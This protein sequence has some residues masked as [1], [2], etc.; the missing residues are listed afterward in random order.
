V[1]G[2]RV[3]EPVAEVGLRAL[4]VDA[5]RD[6]RESLASLV[7]QAGFEPT[8]TGSVEQARALCAQ[9]S[10]D[11]VLVELEIPAGGGLAL[12]RDPDRPAE[13]VVMTSS[14]SVE[15][16]VAA[17]RAG[18]IDY[19]TKP[20]DRARLGTVLG[21]IARTRALRAEVS[22]LRGEL[23]ELGRYGYLVGNSPPMQ[24]V[25]RLISKVA[26]TS[27]TVLIVGESGTGKELVAQ[28]I[29]RESRRSAGRFVAVNC[30]ALSASLAE[31][32]LFGHE[33]G[34]FTGAEA[35]RAGYFEEASG[36]TLFLDEITE[37]P[38]EL[39]VK[40]LRVLEAGSVRRVGGSESIPVDVRLMAASN[41]DPQ[42][43]VER[44]QLRR[45]VLYRLS[46]FPI[47]VPPLRERDGDVELLAH[48]FLE[49]VNQRDGSAKHF[50]KAA[51]ECLRAY[52]WP[53]NVREL[54]NAVERAAIVADR[55]IEPGDLPRELREHPDVP[56]VS[57]EE[58][59]G[60]S[61]A[62][63]VGTTL[64]NLEKRLILATLRRCGGDK[65]RAAAQLGISV[66]TLYQRLSVYRA[67]DGGS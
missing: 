1:A 10:F 25:Y 13:A 5:D 58:D 55:V 29:H 19:L 21:N 11:V 60:D 65:R 63:E 26:P 45:D 20:V 33:K 15:S 3:A 56:A 57:V 6:L 51:L 50:G 27:A 66:R 12:L 64:A 53:G 17:L 2:A 44:G 22:A 32:E 34:S 61:F 9:H 62:V 67:G 38:A 43:S 14:A 41:R 40:L 47:A 30:G 16:A 52:P 35:R 8:L 42:I 59:D 36:G 37:M 24:E 31:S 39:Q 4:I 48:A 18:A 23:Q 46:V 28:M 7:E 54:R 49:R